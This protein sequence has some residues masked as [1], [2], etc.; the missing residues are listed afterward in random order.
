MYEITYL[1]IKEDKTYE[2]TVE[3]VINKCFEEE[4]LID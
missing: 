3:K 4:G 2:K 1:N